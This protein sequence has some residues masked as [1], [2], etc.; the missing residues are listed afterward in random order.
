MILKDITL[1][2]RLLIHNIK[3][4]FSDYLFVKVHSLHYTCD[5]QTNTLLLTINTQSLISQIQHVPA[6]T[7]EERAASGW[8][9]ELASFREKVCST[10]VELLTCSNIKKEKSWSASFLWEQLS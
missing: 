5:S 9:G 6:R 7:E 10:E 1:P 2:L 3:I 4:I 8:K